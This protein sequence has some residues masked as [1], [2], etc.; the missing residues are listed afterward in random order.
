MKKTKLIATMAAMGAIVLVGCSSKKNE[1]EVSSLFS[2]EGASSS[3]TM[4]STALETFDSSMTLGATE[5]TLNSDAS[6]SGESD[7]TLVMSH[8]F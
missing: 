2:E 6:T 4:E 3:E 8:P 7:L 5:E 1:T